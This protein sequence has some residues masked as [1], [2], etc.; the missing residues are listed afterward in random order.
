MY[1]NLPVYS[2]CQ[3]RQ[4][5]RLW[6]RKYQHFRPTK[7]CQVSFKVLWRLYSWAFVKRVKSSVHVSVL[8]VSECTATVQRRSTSRVKIQ[9]P[10]T[11]FIGDLG[12]L[13]PVGSTSNLLSSKQW[14]TGPALL[15]AK[16]YNGII[17]LATLQTVGCSWPFVGSLQLSST[18]NPILIF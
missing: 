15:Q 11:H 17:L 12:R 10:A 3:G 5:W 14:A 1:K 8:S 4:L 2:Q 7:F 16:D 9:C 13:P 6:N 18:N